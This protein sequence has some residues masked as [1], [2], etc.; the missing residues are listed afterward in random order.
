MRTLTCAALAAIGALGGAAAF[1]P[2]NAAGPAPAAGGGRPVPAAGGRQGTRT[3]TQGGTRTP[4]R[5]AAP[6]GR[7]LQPA[8]QL[9]EDYTCGAA[10][11]TRAD[12]RAE[13][14]A[15]R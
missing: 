2:P 11:A 3:H 5:A 6:E 12:E 7:V 4:T 14:A 10:E 15:S 1:S 9:R 8:E 13:P